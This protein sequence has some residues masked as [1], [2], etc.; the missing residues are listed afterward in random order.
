MSKYIHFFGF[1][2]LDNWILEE[3]LLAI[4]DWQLADSFTKKNRHCVN[5]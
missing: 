2:G 3:L 1:L 5:L 4:R